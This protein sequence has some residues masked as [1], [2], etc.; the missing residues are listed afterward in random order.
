MAATINSNW[1]RGDNE[2]V[3]ELRFKDFDECLR[4]VDRVGREAVDVD[5]QRR[6]DMCLLEFHKVRV[7]C[8]NRNH[9]GVT[10]AEERLAGIVDEILLAHHPGARG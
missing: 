7:V 10:L 8:A 6:P 4:F 9:A 5:H 3:R 2:L 1:T